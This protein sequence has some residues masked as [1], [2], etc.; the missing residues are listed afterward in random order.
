MA[1][2]VF[3]LFIHG[4]VHGH[5]RHYVMPVNSVHAP[6]FQFL[7]SQVSHQLI[8]KEDVYVGRQDEASSRPPDAGVLGDHL[9]QRQGFAVAVASVDSGGYFDEPYAAWT[10][11]SGPG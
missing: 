9:I 5:V 10:Q 4:R 2:A 1:P 6:G 11:V 3:Q 7:L 8:R